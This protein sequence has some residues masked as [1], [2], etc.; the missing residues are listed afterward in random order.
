[1][2]VETG[3]WAIRDAREHFPATGTLAYFNTAA[4]SLARQALTASYHRIVDDWSLNGFDFLEAEKLPPRD[5]GPPWPIFLGADAA[6]MALIAS[7]SAAA[8]LVA[9]QFG[10]AGAG[11]SIVIGQR[12]YSESLPVA[13]AD[14]QGLRRPAGPLPKWRPGTGRHCDAGR[15]RDTSSSL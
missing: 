15:R 1:M 5:R 10:P 11:E 8:G 6:D 2:A 12:E 14:R 7:V 13:I 4:T 3:S 9:A